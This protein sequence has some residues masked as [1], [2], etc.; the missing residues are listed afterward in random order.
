[1]MMCGRKRVYAD[2]SGNPQ[3]PP[4]HAGKSSA[5]SLAAKCDEKNIKLGVR[6]RLMNVEEE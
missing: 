5:F 6:W 4:R 3:V 2:V 1:M